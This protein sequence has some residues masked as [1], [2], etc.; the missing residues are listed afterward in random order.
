MTTQRL[1]VKNISKQPKGLERKNLNYLNRIIKLL[2]KNNHNVCNVQW[3]NATKW[4]FIHLFW[5]VQAKSK[6]M[7]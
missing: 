5:S 3:C 6:K 2:M 7:Y 1:S 4:I